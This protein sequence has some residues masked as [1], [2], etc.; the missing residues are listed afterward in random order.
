MGVVICIEC[1]G[2]HRSL[3]VYVSQVRSLTLDSIKPSVVRKLKAIGNTK[4]N[5]VY[6]ALLPEDFDRS[7]LKKGENRQDFIME[8]YVSMKYVT[9]DEKERILRK[10]KQ[11]KV[12][13]P[14]PQCVMYIP[15]HL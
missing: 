5:T 12:L 1:S 8:K 9:P 14:H 3:G 10:S 15:P 7:Q 13:A 6:E 4:S 11:T 2:V